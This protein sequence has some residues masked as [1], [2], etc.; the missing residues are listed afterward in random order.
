MLEDSFA[1]IE[2]LRSFRVRILPSRGTESG[3]KVEMKII[4][5]EVCKYV[6][7]SFRSQFFF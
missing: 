6:K 2:T 1:V 5:R 4:R 3:V 7:S